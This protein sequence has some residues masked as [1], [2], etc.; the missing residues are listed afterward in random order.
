MIRPISL[1]G[2]RTCFRETMKNVAF[3]MGRHCY[4]YEPGQNG[5]AFGGAYLAAWLDTRWYRWQGI[6]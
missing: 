5:G 3:K 4:T 2:L 6:Q 1:N